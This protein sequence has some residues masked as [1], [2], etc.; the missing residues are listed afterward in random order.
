MNIVTDGFIHCL[1]YL[2]TSCVVLYGQDS[3]LSHWIRR[4]DP[5]FGLVDVMEHLHLLTLSF[6]VDEELWR[7]NC[8]RLDVYEEL[9]TEV[10][11]RWNHEKPFLMV[12][13]CREL[14]HL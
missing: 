8:M 3:Q 1:S 7:Y 14:E 6:T 9:D 11:G 10:S 2:R 13:C 4:L 12:K 5:D